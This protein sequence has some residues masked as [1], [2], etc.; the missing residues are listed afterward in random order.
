MVRPNPPDRRVTALRVGAAG[1]VAAA[2]MLYR[3][4]GMN[5]FVAEEWSDRACSA[6]G[7]DAVGRAL[8]LGLS[9]RT[10][11]GAVEAAVP[12]WVNPTLAGLVVVLIVLATASIAL[13]RTRNP[14]TAAA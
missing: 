13:G 4:A 12:A 11:A 8:P 6:A 14:Q 5:V 1:S 3:W 7:G 2:A 10:G 9:C